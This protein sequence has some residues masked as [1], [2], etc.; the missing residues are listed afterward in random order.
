MKDFFTEHNRAVTDRSIMKLKM[1]MSRY[2]F[3]FFILLLTPL[4]A[5]AIL[6]SK[7]DCKAI[8]EG[9]VWKC[10]SKDC[11]AIIKGDVWKCNSENCQAV[12]AGD[13]WQCG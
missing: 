11:E 1:F 8:I 6:L 7:K 12:I 4:L 9:D 3:A 10:V 2:A 5:S 13:V